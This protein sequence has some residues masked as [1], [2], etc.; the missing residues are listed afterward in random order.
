VHKYVAPSSETAKVGLIS[1]I[2]L[3][4][5]F[6]GDI[7]IVAYFIWRHLCFFTRED[8]I[9]VVLSS[10]YHVIQEQ[11]SKLYTTQHNRMGN[12]V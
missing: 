12:P 3:N 1:F 8:D 2:I 6:S 7:K 5:Y 11:E 9:F 4:T 10:I